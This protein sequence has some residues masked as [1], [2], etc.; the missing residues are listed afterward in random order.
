[1]GDLLTGGDAKRRD[2]QL[3]DDAFE[4][5][6]EAAEIIAPRAWVALFSGGHDSLTATTVA[7]EWARARDVPLTAAH[8]R[9]G[10][11]IPATTEYVKEVCAAQ[12]WPLKIYDPPVPYEDIVLEYGF[13]GPGQH[14]IAYNRLKE[15]CLRQIVREAKVEY[16]DRIAFVT[17]VRSDE[18]LRRLRHVDRI[19]KGDGAQWW[20]AAVWN[21]TKIECAKFTFGSRKLPRNPVV[22][23]LHMSAECLC[24]AFARPGEMQEIEAWFPEH[25]A[26]LHD[27]EAKAQAKGLRACRWGQRPPRIHAD[28]MKMVFGEEWDAA[29]PGVMCQGCALSPEE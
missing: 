24:G 10:T 7:F 4:V 18:S 17:G 25:A 16:K 26:W 29:I 28:Q 6:D 27:L 11:G 19:Q 22:D 21:W 20:A 14:G 8:I 1:M 23:L 2:E 9:T 13:M 3:L 15:R 5:L 12:G